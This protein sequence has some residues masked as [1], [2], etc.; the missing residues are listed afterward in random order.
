MEPR[1]LCLTECWPS[2]SVRTSS[3]WQRWGLSLAGAPVCVLSS[4]A[5][6]VV[7]F[8]RG[9][10]GS[11][12]CVI[13]ILFQAA[14][15]AGDGYRARRSP[16][17]PHERFEGLTVLKAMQVSGSVSLPP[18]WLSRKSVCHTSIFLCEVHSGWGHGCVIFLTSTHEVSPDPLHL[19]SCLGMLYMEGLTSAFSPMRQCF[20]IATCPCE[21]TCLA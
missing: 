16:H 11:I 8:L 17:T 20:G 12:V 6:R 18:P 14:G 7:V 5:D 2:L 1:G 4:S 10:D 13:C 15:E 19:Q 9:R 3:D 21:G